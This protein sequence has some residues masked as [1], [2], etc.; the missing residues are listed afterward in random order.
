MPVIQR[1]AWLV[2][3]LVAAVALLWRDAYERGKTDARVAASAATIRTLRDTV[4]VRDVEYRRDTVRLTRWRERWDSVR[5]TDT[6]AVA[7]IVY[8][9][10][11][12]A[13]STIQACYSVLRSCEV[14]VAA[15]DTL[16]R[17]LE[18]SLRAERA[19]RPSAVRVALDRALWAAVGVGVGAVFLAR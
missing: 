6:V 15:R 11:A 10:R 14:R 13:D 2:L 3:A 19:S 8:V 1:Q 18:S 7:K 12:V 16:I 4:R 9:P 5:V 17:A